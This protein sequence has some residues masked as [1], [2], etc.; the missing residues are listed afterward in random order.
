MASMAISNSAPNMLA[1][2]DAHGNDEPRSEQDVGVLK[3]RL[4]RVVDDGK[5]I[6]R[7]RE[8][9]HPCVDHPR[10]SNEQI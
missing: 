4:P 7:L 1:P 6:V 9:A 10:A 8:V 5:R 3:L 2:D